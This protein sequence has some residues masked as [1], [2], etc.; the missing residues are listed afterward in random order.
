MKRAYGI[1]FRENGYKT[2]FEIVLSPTHSIIH[3]YN[4]DILFFSIR[5]DQLIN[6]NELIKDINEQ[7]YILENGEF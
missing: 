1:H 2:N 7:L 5:Q 4:S 6:E 3:I